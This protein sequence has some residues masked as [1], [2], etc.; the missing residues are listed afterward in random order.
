MTQRPRA[1]ESRKSIPPTKL[2]HFVLRTRSLA[3]MKEWWSTLLGAEVV[4]ENAMIAFLTYDDEHHRLALVELPDLEDRPERS[5]GVDHVAFTYAGLGELLG[6]YERLKHL[7][8]KPYWCVNHG[9]TTSLYFRDPDGNQVELQVDN[10][11]R[12]DELM[13]WMRSGAFERNPIGV[14]FDPDR[15]LERYRRG[16]P[17]EEL[18][19]Q[20]GV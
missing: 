11:P 8:V 6:T 2:A 4:F 14:P 3:A 7:G 10:F 17:V 13:A 18:V 5:V 9:P 12:A 1:V 19:Q 15:L 16:D 20:G